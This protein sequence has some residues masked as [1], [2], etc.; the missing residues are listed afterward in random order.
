MQE[1]QAEQSGLGEE[2]AKGYAPKRGG[3]MA[4]WILVVLGV[5]FLLNNF[6]PIDFGRFWPVLLIVIGIVL[7]AG[8]SSR[9]ERD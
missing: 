3:R 6:T 7:L 5:L 8:R 2:P 9:H 4:G 1:Q